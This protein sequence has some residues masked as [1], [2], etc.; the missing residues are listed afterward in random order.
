MTDVQINNKKN[1]SNE[2]KVRFGIE[3]CHRG[4][5]LGKNN[6]QM[7]AKIQDEGVE[8]EMLKAESY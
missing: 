6:R 7:L 8:K 4:P 5:P 1:N 2:F 3:G